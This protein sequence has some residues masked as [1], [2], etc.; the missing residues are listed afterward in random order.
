MAIEFEVKLKNVV[1]PSF[2]KKAVDDFLSERTLETCVLIQSETNNENSELGRGILAVGSNAEVS[3]EM[4][5]VEGLGD[6]EE[7]GLW[8]TFGVDRVRTGESLFLAVLLAVVAARDVNTDVFD[9]W[10]FFG[11]GRLLPWRKLFNQL[12]DIPFPSSGLPSLGEFGE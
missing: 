2:L 1:D 10:Q 9:E 7:E 11:Q 6:S 5:R 12:E 4:N 8:L 3:F